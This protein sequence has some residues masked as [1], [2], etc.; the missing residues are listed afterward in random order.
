M[1]DE[2]SPDNIYSL[3]YYD[4]EL[5]EYNVCSMI[6]QEKERKIDNYPT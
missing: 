3:L 5:S 2:S 6:D 4:S 1:K